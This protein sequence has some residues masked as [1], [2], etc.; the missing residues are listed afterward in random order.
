MHRNVIETIMGAVVLIVA[1]VFLV[2]AYSSSS[3]GTVSGYAVTARFNNISGINPGT[4]VRL[5]GIKVGSVIDTTLDTNDYTAL[6][7]LSIKDTVK[8]PTD[9]ALR[10]WSD[11]L[12][13]PSYLDL[14]PGADEKM[15]KEGDRIA[16]TQDPVNLL[17]LI[18][19][20]IHGG[21]LGGK[22]GGSQTPPTTSPQ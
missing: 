22:S 18:T 15:L 19:Q 2:F 12:L 10:V 13:S 9:T 20:L 11:G 8:L 7:S 21:A 4:D 16:V 6:V 3:S 14:Q 5:S 1:V 17:G